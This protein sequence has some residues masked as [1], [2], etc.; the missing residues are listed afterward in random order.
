[1]RW[2]PLVLVCA[3]AC[4]PRAVTPPSRTFVMSAPGAAPAPGGTDVQLDAASIGTMW[5]PELVGG[6]ARLRHTLEPGV[7]LEADGGILHVTNP[8]QGGDRNGYTGRLGVMLRSESGRWALGAG[9][10]GGTSPTAGSWGAADVYGAVSGKHRYFRP[11]IALG[12]GYSAP[13]G[14]TTFVVHDPDSDDQPM[15]TLRLPRNVISATHVGIEL[16]PPEA[17]LVVGA[18]MLRFWVRDDSVVQPTEESDPEDE[19][20]LAV[21]GGFRFTIR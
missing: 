5:G 11:M 2:L 20:F 21:G 1:M 18:S 10:G 16:G 19:M 4:T 3:A 13:F 6:N 12:V 17:A 8:G 14:D 15:T 9:L 7:T